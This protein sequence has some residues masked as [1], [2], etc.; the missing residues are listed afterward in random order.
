MLLMRGQQVYGLG[1]SGAVED[2]S[3]GVHAHIQDQ[4]EHLGVIYTQVEL[5]QGTHCLLH[6]TLLDS[7]LVVQEET[8]QHG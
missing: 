2:V 1:S 6:L 8:I 3:Y 5:L 7:T 4:S